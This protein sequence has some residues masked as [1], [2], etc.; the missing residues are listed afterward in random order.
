MTVFNVHFTLR[1]AFGR[2]TR[3]MYQTEDISDLDVGAEFLTA[4]NE[5]AL[6]MADLQA[7]TLAEVLYYTVQ[8]Q[9]AVVDTADVGANI[10]EGITLVVDKSDNKAAILKVPAPTLTVVNADGSVDITA[11]AVT[12]YHD[13]F[14]TSGK[15][16]VSDGE[17]ATALI[18]GRL[19]R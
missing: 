1:D 4:Y 6:L 3:K 2:R 15:F 8:A 19:D 7:L 14:T 12:N 10:D 5:A 11:G 16:T 17:K 18:S 13:N 9:V